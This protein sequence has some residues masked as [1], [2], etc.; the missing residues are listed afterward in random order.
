[1]AHPG[2]CLAANSDTFVINAQPKSEILGN[3]PERRRCS[4]DLRRA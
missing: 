1:M 3:A 4:R 2:V